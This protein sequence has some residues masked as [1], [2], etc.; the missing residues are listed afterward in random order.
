MSNISARVFPSLNLK[1]RI[2]L[3][4]LVDVSQE[5]QS[6]KRIDTDPTGFHSVSVKPTK[7]YGNP[8]HVTTFGSL[9]LES[10]KIRCDPTIGFERNPT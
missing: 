10:G 3:Y 1:H 6:D 8:G 2:L 5:I 9:V 7:S 4:K